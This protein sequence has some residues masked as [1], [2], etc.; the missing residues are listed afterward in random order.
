MDEIDRLVKAWDD[1]GINPRLHRALKKQLYREWPTLAV[2]IA[3][4][5]EKE[6]GPVYPQLGM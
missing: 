1:E 2:A 5:A 4:I 3:K 6:R